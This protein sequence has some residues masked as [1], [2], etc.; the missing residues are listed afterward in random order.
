MVQYRLTIVIVAFASDRR[1]RISSDGGDGVFTSWGYANLHCSFH[2][3]IWGGL[4]GRRGVGCARSCSHV[5]SIS[6]GCGSMFV[7]SVIG[8]SSIPIALSPCSR[9]ISI[10]A[11]SRTHDSIPVVV[12]FVKEVGHWE[13]GWLLQQWW[14]MVAGVAEERETLVVEQS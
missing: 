9:H 13:V 6:S 5:G 10:F 8:V 12:A 14:S 11:E 2:L 4:S 3:G 7:H 1:G